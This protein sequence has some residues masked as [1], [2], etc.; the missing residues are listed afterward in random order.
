MKKMYSP[1]KENINYSTVNN[2]WEGKYSG[3]HK[4]LLT[5]CGNESE[6]GTIWISLL[7]VTCRQ[8]EEDASCESVEFLQH[9]VNLEL[10]VYS[11]LRQY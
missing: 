10:L 2:I 11:R 1:T 3:K 8:F 6:Y 4:L 9:I 5:M 7:K